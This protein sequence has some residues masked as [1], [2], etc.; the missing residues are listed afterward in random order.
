MASGSLGDG[1]VG[2]G[3]CGINADINPGDAGT[4]EGL[5]SR[6]RQR[7]QASWSKLDARRVDHDYGHHR[8][9]G[10]SDGHEIRVLE[11][12]SPREVDLS[13]WGDEGNPPHN[14]GH[15]CLRSPPW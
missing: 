5:E 11:W 10:G 4:L 15:R 12:F 14:V 9:G 8:T 13:T 3:V 1:V 7:S 2:T 6:S